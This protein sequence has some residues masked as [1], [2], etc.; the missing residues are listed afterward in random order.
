MNREIKFR[1]WDGQEMSEW[2]EIT[3]DVPQLHHHHI[4]D[5]F[6]EWAQEPNVFMQY[7]GLKDKNSKEVYEG[8][9]VACS[10]GCPHEVI[11]EEAS[12]FG[13]MGGWNLSGLKPGAKYDWIVD[14][15]E[16]IGNIYENP[17]LLEVQNGSK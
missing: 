2:E 16:V 6:E 14:S 4:A 11:W 13:D 17:E 8:D 9:L 10:S 15:T 12:M 7:T 3:F 5:I 1:I